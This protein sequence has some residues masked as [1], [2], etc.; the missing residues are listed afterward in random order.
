[1]RLEN[2]SR[3]HADLLPPKTIFFEMNTG[4]LFDSRPVSVANRGVF[5]IYALT[6]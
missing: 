5:W 4:A 3:D 1:L 6:Y 2:F